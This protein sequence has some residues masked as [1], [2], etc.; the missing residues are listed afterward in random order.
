MYRENHIILKI[1][2]KNLRTE[3]LETLP[4]I[5]DF[6]KE[7]HTLGYGFKNLKKR[8]GFLFFVISICDHLA[9]VPLAGLDRV[10]P[11][12][13]GPSSH[14]ERSAQTAGSGTALATPCP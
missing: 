2:R 14:T 4:N 6:Q 1:S 5:C 3:T 7:N 12:D 13:P 8:F 9:V 10:A 11:A